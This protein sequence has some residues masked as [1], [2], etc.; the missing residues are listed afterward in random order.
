MD[1]L[2]VQLAR[3]YKDRYYGKYRGFVTDNADPDQMG[4][5]R[6]KVPA[7]LGDAE[8]GWALPSTPFGGEKDQG[9]FMIPEVGAQ[10]WMEFE[11]GNVDTPIWTG[12]LWKSN[13]DP[14]KE[15]AKNPPATRILKTPSGHI[16]QFDDD[17]GS[18]QIILSHPKGSSLTIDKNGTVIL[19]DSQGDK[20]TLDAS[21][22]KVVLEDANGNTLTM[23]SSGSS[24]EDCNGNKIDMTS[25]GIT[26]KGTQIVLDG[27]QVML[28]GSG[29]EP[30][31]KG[32]TFLTML[33][34]HMHPSAMGPTGPPIPQGEMSSLSQKVMTS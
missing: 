32:T 28:G 17:S 34:T 9:F 31:I 26:I 11:A 16:L 22:K 24:L 13:G 5:V 21:N 6:A 29:G 19:A 8:S 10:V 14:P 33:A 3:Q 27:T 18:E 4:R 30:I 20:I 15:S 2:L 7:V 1:D 25:S 23:A 12:T